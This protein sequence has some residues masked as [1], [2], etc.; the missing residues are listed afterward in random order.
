M[1][2]GEGGFC[3]GGIQNGFH[4]IR[5]VFNLFGK[6]LGGLDGIT[7]QN[8]N[9]KAGGQNQF[10]PTHRSRSEIVCSQ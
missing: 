9:Q 2:I 8:T 3:V 5:I 4:I 10:D 7:A 6:L 1:G